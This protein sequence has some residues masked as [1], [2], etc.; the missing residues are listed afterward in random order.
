MTLNKVRTNA[1]MKRTLP[2]SPAASR[3]ATSSGIERTIAGDGTFAD[4]QSVATGWVLGVGGST[5]SLNDLAA[6]G[7]GPSHLII[8]GPD[9][10]AVYSVANGSIA[11]NKAH[12]AF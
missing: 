1:R 9:G 6:G 11:G 4:G 5:L 2:G 7:A 8:G 3:L 12:N 10:S